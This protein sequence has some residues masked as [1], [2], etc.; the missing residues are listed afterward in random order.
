MSKTC[1]IGV[2]NLYRSDDAAGLAVS[3]I[4]A[5]A[6]VPGVRVCEHDGEPAGLLD[7][8]AGA[9]RAYVAD[10]VKSGADP[11]TVHWVDVTEKDL[12]SG[13]GSPSSHH[14]SIAEAV[15]LARVLGRLPTRLV[16]VGIEGV[17]VTAGVGLTPVVSRGVDAAAGRILAAVRASQARRPR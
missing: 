11:G 6:E 16:I 14:L 12:P 15:S 9:D 1:V 2:G 13:L 8:W 5:A 4:V 7:L 3:A 10:M 17:S